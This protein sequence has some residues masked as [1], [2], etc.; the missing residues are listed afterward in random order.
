MSQLV[1]ALVQA[2]IGQGLFSKPN[3][4]R[5]RSSLRMSFKQLMDAFIMWIRR[6]CFIPVF[7]LAAFLVAQKGQF[8]KWRLRVRDHSPQQDFIVAQQSLNSGFI[9]QIRVELNAGG[10]AP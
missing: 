9:K 10:K 2:S 3:R 4:D 6:E 5:L 1:G 7:D 8:P